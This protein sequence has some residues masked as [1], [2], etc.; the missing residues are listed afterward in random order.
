M[1]PAEFRSLVRRG[2]WTKHVIKACIG[3]TRFNLA[4]VPKELAFEF[5]LF[6]QRNPQ[7]CAVTDATEPGDPHPKLLAPEA[8]LRTDLPRYRVYED[9]ELIDEPTDVT[10]YWRDDLVAFLIGAIPNIYWLLQNASVRYR[11]IGDFTTNIPTIPTRRFHGSMVVS[12]TLFKSSYDAVRAIQISSRLPAGHGAPVHI[13]DPAI[14]GIGDLYHP[15]I[16]HPVPVAPQET[17]EIALYWGCGVTPQSVAIEAK[18]PFMITHKPGHL[19]IS[20]RRAEELAI[21]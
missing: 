6:S 12:A 21:L 11:L 4:V 10:K 3:F 16:F 19:L 18:I 8:D 5:L 1:S 2:E 15:D 13:G 20:D 17:G 14:I 7:A 9:G